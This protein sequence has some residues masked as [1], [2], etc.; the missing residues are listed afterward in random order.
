MDDPGLPP[1]CGM[2]RCACAFVRLRR[3][4]A[5]RR[6]PLHPLIILIDVVGPFYLAACFMTWNDIRE[7]AASPSPRKER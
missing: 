4:S 6:F 3:F 5:L 7:Q 2:G 1:W